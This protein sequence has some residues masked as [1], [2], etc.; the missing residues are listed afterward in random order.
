MR[1]DI[2]ICRSESKPPGR[3]HC[4]LWR[5]LVLF[6]S[7]SVAWAEPEAARERNS[8]YLFIVD[9]T[10]S[11]DR[12]KAQLQATLFD[13]INGGVEGWMHPGDTIGFW[14]FADRVNEEFPM[15]VWEETR[16]EA[17][18]KRLAAEVARQRFDKQGHFGP[19]L[20]DMMEVIR[21]AEDVT[22]LIFTDGEEPLKGTKHDAT[23]N[24]VMKQI[25]PE[26]RAGKK[27]IVISLVAR[28]GQFVNWG[29]NSPELRV[30]LP[31]PPVEERSVVTNQRPP[32]IAGSTTTS[33]NLVLPRVASTLKN[34]IT[35]RSS[36]PPRAPESGNDLS[37]RR[38]PAPEK[39]GPEK[40]NVIKVASAQGAAGTPPH[41][42]AFQT[43]AVAKPILFAALPAAATNV[44]PSTEKR[45][46]TNISVF[47]EKPSVPKL[48]PSPTVLRPPPQPIII[49]RTSTAPPVPAS[50]NPPAPVIVEHK[51]SA[52]PVAVLPPLVVRT[53]SVK[54]VLITSTV[55]A[56]VFMELSNQ[57]KTP[58][59]VEAA[60][61]ESPT[62]EA[63]RTDPEERDVPESAEPPSGESAPAF[64]RQG[65]TLMM[66]VGCL[67]AALAVGLLLWR[68]KKRRP[69]QPSL[70][71]RGLNRSSRSA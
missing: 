52:P 34:A 4:W 68:S 67:T 33:T 55:P 39:P 9:T 23:I 42:T 5:W 35:P 59:S 27:P 13:L 66:G 36:A 56:V 51:V 14:T 7:L 20:A 24:A 6:L 25:A 26:M 71:T 19:V 1:V 54:E 48:T 16:K 47:T 32:V 53:N 64:L 45:A 41:A 2:P 8:R 46:T 3:Q 44:S 37:E 50:S 63:G 62:G 12:L 21:S 11:M 43:Q 60:R 65:Q 29:V 22:V 49:T 10:F 58:A 70:I 57:V 15:Q 61:R 31:Q 17:L 18:G 28:G 38:T 40:T 69:P 30:P